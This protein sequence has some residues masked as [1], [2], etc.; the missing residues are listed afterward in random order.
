M[1]CCASASENQ[2]LVITTY[3][4]KRTVRNGPGLMCVGCVESVDKRP[5]LMLSQGEYTRVTNEEDG[6]CRIVAGPTVLFLGPR[7]RAAVVGQLPVLRPGQY[8]KLRDGRTGDV[9]VEHGPQV[10]ELGA[11]EEVLVDVSTSPVLQKSEFCVV[12]D[13]RSGEVRSVY[14][15]AMVLLKEHETVLRDVAELPVLRQGEFVKVKDT[16]SGDMRI[17]EGPMVVQLGPTD[18]VLDGGVQKLPV[19]RRG[20]Y[21]KVK[22]VRDGEVRVFHGPCH[23]SMGVHDELARTR[24]GAILRCPDLSGDEY[25]VVRN[26]A[27]GT[28]WNEVG[29]QVFKPGPFDVFGPAQKIINLGKI[30]YVRIRHAD[31]RVSVETGEQRLVPEPLDV[32]ESGVQQAVNVDEHNAVLIRNLDSGSLELVTRHGIFFPSAYQEIVKVQEKI[33]LEPYETVVCR[34]TD[35][36][37][38]YASGDPSAPAEERGPG[39]NFFLPPHHELV[40]QSWS[41]DLRKEHATATDVWKFDSRPSY[42]NYEF[43]CR[44]LDNVELVIDVYFFWRIIDVR[45]MVTSTAD[46]PGDT[47]THARSMI[48]QEV[49]AVKLMD[50]L[51]NFN[52]MVRRAVL[53]DPFY[54]ERGIELISAEV[55]KFECTNGDTNQ[56]LREIIQETCD[57]LKRTERQRGE[58]EV[59]MARLD[60]EIAEER[61]RQELVEVKKSHL[62]VEARIEG[63]AEGTRIAAFLSKLAQHDED[64]IG[65][66]KEKAFQIYEM[67]RRY[68]AMAQQNSEKRKAVEALGQGTAQLYV[69]PDDVNLHF[70][71]FQNPMRQ[72]GQAPALPLKCGQRAGR[73]DV[74]DMEEEPY[75]RY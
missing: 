65:I 19:L 56:I 28:M 25:L 62:R 47:C 55:L 54:A 57:R 75:V 69:M 66:G 7:E 73:A 15:P 59:A 44:T 11:Y 64:G 30:D 42:M 41:T 27:E 2:Q 18:Q 23:V 10:V 31:G 51:E 21:C 14:G 29:P 46:A 33:I 5:A 63:E 74:G 37:F 6:G 24:A 8:C 49:S 72:P 70:G 20:E 68:Q 16:E 61:K 71:T 26:E 1:G 39:P 12:K 36:V 58:N 40:S 50:F 9:R 45:S 35:G 3:T 4:G 34:D 48:M 22:N 17:E 60:G 32:V 52:K 38:Y 53:G 43:N 13:Q 67:Q